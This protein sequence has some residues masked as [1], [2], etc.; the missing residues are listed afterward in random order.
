MGL[1]TDAYE[2]RWRKQDSMYDGFDVW[3]RITLSDENEN[4]IEELK[5]F[6]EDCYENIMAVGRSYKEKGDYKKY[7]DLYTF[8]P[9]MKD[10]YK[11]LK[12]YLASEGYDVNQWLFYVKDAVSHII[13]WHKRKS[14]DHSLRKMNINPYGLCKWNSTEGGH[15][16]CFFGDQVLPG[17]ET[18]YIDSKD[19]WKVKHLFEDIDACES[20][21]LPFT[22]KSISVVKP[23]RGQECLL[24]F[25]KENISEDNE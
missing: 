21:L 2:A 7:N 22:M 17:L 1:F 10:D 16:I 14:T 3:L 4:A 8:T 6:T 20:G 5:T 19:T 11:F 9:Y 25:F 13:A 18:F 24:F 15:K 23:K 12:N